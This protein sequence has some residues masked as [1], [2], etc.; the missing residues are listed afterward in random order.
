MRFQP[1]QARYDSLAYPV[2]KEERTQ[3]PGRVAVGLLAL[4]GLGVGGEPG[5][6]AAE[7]LRPGHDPEGNQIK[8]GEH[9]TSL[10]F[11]PAGARGRLWRARDETAIPC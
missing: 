11:F 9:H 10:S 1:G 8:G 2:L 7:T 4:Q 6:G 5:A 3:P